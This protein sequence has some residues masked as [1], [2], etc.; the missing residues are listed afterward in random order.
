MLP[1]FSARHTQF[2]HHS[3]LHVPLPAQASP[4][5]APITIIVHARNRRVQANSQVTL[6]RKGVFFCS[7]S[8]LS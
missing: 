7:E 5:E 1:Q 2:L 4:A 3:V 8:W 6:R